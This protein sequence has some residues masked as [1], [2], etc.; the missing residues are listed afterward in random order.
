VSETMVD[1]EAVA[2][3]SD[4]VVTNAL[5]ACRHVLDPEAQAP[6]AILAGAVMALVR[7]SIQSMFIAPAVPTVRSVLSTFIGVVNKSAEALLA[8]PATPE[9]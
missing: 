7:Y 5:N 3:D 1:Y 6:G 9:N 2:R 4:T 8:K